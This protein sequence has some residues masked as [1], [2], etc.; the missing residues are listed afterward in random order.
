MTDLSKGKR[1]I[2]PKTKNYSSFIKPII[3]KSCFYLTLVVLTVDGMKLLEKIRCA[4]DKSGN[5][6]CTCPDDPITEIYVNKE[7]ENC[8]S[9]YLCHLGV[10]FKMQCGL[11][12]AFHPKVKQ[13]MPRTKVPTNVCKPGKRPF[14][15]MYHFSNL[16]I[17][18]NKQLNYLVVDCPRGGRD[19]YIED[20]DDC[21]KFYLCWEGK[22][23][24]GTCPG[25][26]TID[27]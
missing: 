20:Q 13:C 24:H 16:L 15:M 23:F 12:K 21:T 19:R 22:D 6:N 25:N 7:D 17:R 10:A 14:Y 1:N 5:K 8:E 3:L 9:Y 2:I 11:Y 26:R 18:L 27:I 4:K